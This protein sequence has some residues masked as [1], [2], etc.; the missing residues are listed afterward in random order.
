VAGQYL[1]K[2]NISHIS[3]GKLAK[4]KCTIKAYCRSDK[5]I[6]RLLGNWSEQRWEYLF[7][8]S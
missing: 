2:D 4:R 8:A 7:I 6:R 1:L 3:E 5:I